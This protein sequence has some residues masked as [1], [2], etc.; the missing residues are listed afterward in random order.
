MSEC[1]APNRVRAEAVVQ[2]VT[3][4]EGG[5]R[6]PSGLTLGVVTAATLSWS[7]FQLWYLSP[8]PFALGFGV[9]NETEARA[10]HLA[11][12]V[13]LTFL[14]FP[15]FKRSPRGW[16]PAWDWGLAGAAAF[17]SAYLYVFHAGLA[18]R[19]GLPTALDMAVGMVGILALLEASRRA[20]GPPLMVVAGAFLAYAFLGPYMPDV[21]AHKGVG[22]AKAVSHYWLT[23][24]GVFG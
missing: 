16:I 20:L 23:T 3:A 5:A 13:F 24:E 21:I 17:S 1:S 22:A 9:L 18:D 4:A 11:F 6:K 12:A 15:A 19:P 7:V 2:D 8:L 10:V 14:M